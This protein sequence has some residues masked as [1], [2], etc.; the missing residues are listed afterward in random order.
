MKKTR[1]VIRDDD[2][3]S[4]SICFHS[5]WGTVNELGFYGNVDITATRLQ[6]ADNK[7]YSESIGYTDA[8][9]TVASTASALN[10]FLGNTGRTWSASTNYMKGIF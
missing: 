9:A 7:W 10:T 1:S 5:K 2:Y 6:A 8:T 4:G 3:D